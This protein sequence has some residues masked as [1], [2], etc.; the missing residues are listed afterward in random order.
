[1]PINHDLDADIVDW[2][3]VLFKSWHG[4]YLRGIKQGTVPELEQTAWQQ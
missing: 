4:S 2:K 3:T 1:M